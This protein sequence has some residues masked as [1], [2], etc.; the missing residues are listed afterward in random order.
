MGGDKQLVRTIQSSESLRDKCELPGF[1]NVS[2]IDR[3]FI[4]SKLNELPI[5]MK[6]DFNF[7]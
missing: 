7:S 5:F 3:L 6:L 4:F 1:D 2:N